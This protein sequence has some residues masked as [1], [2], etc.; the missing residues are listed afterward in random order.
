MAAKRNDCMALLESGNEYR[1]RRLQPASSDSPA[2]VGGESLSE[3][4][5]S[6][7]SRT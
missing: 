3:K 2:T 6:A 1:K 7:N 5:F 4:Q